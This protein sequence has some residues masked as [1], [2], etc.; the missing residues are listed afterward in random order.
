MPPLPRAPPA[1]TGNTSGAPRLKIIN[2]PA[3]YVYLHTSLPCAKSFT[4][5]A[6]A[7]DSQDDTD[8]DP[9]M[10]TDEGTATG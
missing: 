10:L 3:G 5:N 9:D 2:L 6:S 1:A 4:P 8:F 7:E